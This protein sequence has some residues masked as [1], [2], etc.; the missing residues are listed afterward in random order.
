MPAATAHILESC[1]CRSAVLP[2]RLAQT[3][4]Q[5]GMQR[6]GPTRPGTETTV[7]NQLRLNAYALP[8]LPSDRWDRGIK[9]RCT[10]LGRLRSQAGVSLEEGIVTVTVAFSPA[11]QQ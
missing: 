4:Q 11:L 5:T 3:Q 6:S 7:T 9:A 1:E 8:E 2:T 10:L